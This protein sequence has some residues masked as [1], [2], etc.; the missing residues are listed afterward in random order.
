LTTKLTQRL[1]LIIRFANLRKPDRSITVAALLPRLLTFAAD[2]E[3]F[4]GCDS[5]IADTEPSATIVLRLLVFALHNF[6]FNFQRP[7]RVNF[8]TRSLDHH[9]SPPLPQGHGSDCFPIPDAEYLSIRCS[10]F[11]TGCYFD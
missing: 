4:L 6:V 11:E 7:L 8:A 10:P 1:S 2:T 3:Q 9:Q 5:K